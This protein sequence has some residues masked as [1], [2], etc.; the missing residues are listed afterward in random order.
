MSHKLLLTAGNAGCGYYALVKF[1][2]ESEIKECW[3]TA[4]SDKK[5]QDAITSLV[6]ETGKS[7]EFFQ[8]V[9]LDLADYTSV[10]KA[11]QALP[12]DID[13]FCFNAGGAYGGMHELGVTNTYIPTLGHA[14]LLDQLLEMDKVPKGSRIAYVSSETAR[15]VWSFA[16]LLPGFGRCGVF[17]NFCLSSMWGEANVEDAITRDVSGCGDPCCIRGHCLPFRGRLQQYANGKL[18]GSLYFGQIAKDNPELNVIS[19]SPGAIAD[20]EKS[21]FVNAVGFPVKNLMRLMPSLFEM[22]GVAHTM[23][24][25]VQRYV[26]L[27]TGEEKYSSG[28][29]PMSGELLCKC[30]CFPGCAWGGKG[31]LGDNRSMS[32]LLRDD[33]G[34]LKKKAFEVTQKWMKNWSENAGTYSSVPITPSASAGA[35]KGFSKEIAPEEESMN[36]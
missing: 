3:L 10:I 17:S 20:P 23:D 6:K 26:E 13:R 29:M 1:A 24:A 15:P 11:A 25:G 35:N 14:I 36:R 9:V 21:S 7:R 32:A 12:S 5:A 28:S 18:V 16:G 27:L 22:I 19:I 33:D 31:K 30:L 34:K 4:R 8:H 2:K